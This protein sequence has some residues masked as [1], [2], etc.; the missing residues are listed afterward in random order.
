MKRSLGGCQYHVAHP[1]GLSYQA[2]P[3]NA[4]EAESRRLSRFT[5]MGHTPGL[6]NV[7]AATINQPGSKEFPF[8]L[9]MR[10]V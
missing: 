8:T 4:N 2:L 6:M 1:G 9:D 3:V 5:A 7:P 10:R